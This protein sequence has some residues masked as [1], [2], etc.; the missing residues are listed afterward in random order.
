MAEYIVL[1][2]LW[3]P[4]FQVQIQR[5]RGKL[6]LTNVRVNWPWWSKPRKS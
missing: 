2:A 5:V 1:V 4:G 3:V 6:R